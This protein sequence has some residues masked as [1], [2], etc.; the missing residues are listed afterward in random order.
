MKKRMRLGVFALALTVSLSLLRTVAYAATSLSLYSGNLTITDNNGSSGTGNETDG[1]TIKTKGNT[2]STKTNTITFTNK[3][4]TAKVLKFSY[5]VSN[6]ESYT[7]GENT[8]KIETTLAANGGTFVCTVTAKKYSQTATLTINNIS[9]TDPAASSSITVNFDSNIGS[10]TVGSATATSGTAVT[11]VSTSAATTIVATPAS[12]VSFLGWLNESTHTFLSTSATHTQ[13]FGEDITLKAIFS[14]N[15][16][17]STACF[18]VGPIVTDRELT[19]SGYVYHYSVPTYTA[20]FDNLTEANAY[21]VSSGHA[22]IVLLNNGTL[23]GS[24]SISSGVTLLIPNDDEKHT[25]FVGK[26]GNDGGDTYTT[27]TPYRTLT[28]ASGANITVNGAVCV[29][30][31]LGTAMGNSQNG[32]P[33]GPLGFIAMKTGS[34]ITVNTDANLY[35][36]GY[37]TGSGSVEIKSGG[38]VYENFQV[39]DWRGGSV[40]SDMVGNSNKVFPLSQFYIQN[41]EVPLNLNTG[42]AEV[43]STAMTITAVGVQ[44]PCPEFI[45]DSGLFVIEDGYIIKDYDEVTGRTIFTIQGD[46]SISNLAIT[47]NAGV[48]IGDITINSSDYVLPIPS[49]LSLTVESGTITATQDIA[50]LPGSELLISESAA[51]NMGSGNSLYVYDADDRGNYCY[52]QGGNPAKD[53]TYCPLLYAPGGAKDQSGFVKNDAKV[54]VNGVLNASAGGLYTTNGGAN[55]YSTGTGQVVFGANTADNDLTTYQYSQLDGGDGYGGVEEY[56]DIKVTS[57]KLKHENGEHL[58][59]SASTTYNHNHYTCLVDG[60]T[61]SDSTIAK[62]GKWYAGTHANTSVVTPPTC[63]DAGYTTYT[64]ACG[65]SYTGN[66]VAATGHTAADAVKE[67]ETATSY[68]LVVYCS[69]CGTEISRET[70]QIAIYSVTI[71][72]SQTSNATYIPAQTTYTWSPTQL[73]YTSSTTAAKWQGTSQMTITVDNS[74]ST[75]KVLARFAYADN[76]SDSAS[77]TQLWTDLADGVLSVAA[78]DKGS[79]TLTLTPTGTPTKPDSGSEI[80]LGTVTITFEK[81]G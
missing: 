14:K 20:I 25:I 56:V 24:H 1:V 46:L 48:L 17:T 74:Q 31:K 16:G 65:H 47:L 49:H 15:D 63:T 57:A 39:R 77:A 21:A 81:G 12:G 69:V 11:G 60:D 34:K 73:K 38:T 3:A 40:T 52:F 45:G 50:L 53:S 13:I 32:A 68:D 58:D 54:V 59:T 62:C 27:P 19:L 37:I 41:I 26:P 10:I 67:N 78:G 9:F 23:T 22:G 33:S 30:G 4:S 71:T 55:I 80:I 44:N 72:W 5:S 66:T 51:I 70:I 2:L 79:T 76:S 64:C 6:C 7:I 75:G 42:A 28:M 61:T 36:W 43:V 35:A 18:G 29:A 8:G